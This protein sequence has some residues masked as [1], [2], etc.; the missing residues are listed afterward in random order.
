MK[1]TWKWDTKS[2]VEIRESQRSFLM[3]NTLI[4]LS[5]SHLI[6]ESAVGVGRRSA[7]DEVIAAVASREEEELGLQK[8]FTTNNFLASTLIM[9]I[10]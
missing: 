3:H 6:L 7:V 10:N 5:L 9:V 4:S 2:E 1:S 8:Y